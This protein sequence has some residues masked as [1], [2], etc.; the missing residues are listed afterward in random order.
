MSGVNLWVDGSVD[1]HHSFVLL[2][3]IETFPYIFCGIL[4]HDWHILPWPMHIYKKE[5]I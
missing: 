5:P 4:N 2:S 1:S 3:L